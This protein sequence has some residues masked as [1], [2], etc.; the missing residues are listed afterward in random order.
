MMCKFL[1]QVCIYSFQTSPGAVAVTNSFFGRGTVEQYSGSYQCS[2]REVSL[3][4]C[5]KG[6]GDDRC[7]H[8]NDAG[9]LCPG[10]FNIESSYRLTMMMMTLFCNTI[11]RTSLPNLI[12]RDAACVE[13]SVRL[14]GGTSDAEGR[15]EVCIGGK[16]GTVCDDSWDNTAASVVCQQLGYSTECNWNRVWVV[17]HLA[18]CTCVVVSLWSSVIMHIHKCRKLCLLFRGPSLFSQA[19]WV[20]VWK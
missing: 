12:A 8:F 13:G 15:V 3:N 18:N 2:G 19:G 5:P 6:T 1:Q 10:N 17:V 20:N 4:S 11:V 9:V 16:W 14:V 7:S